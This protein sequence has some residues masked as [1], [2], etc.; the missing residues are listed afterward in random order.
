MSEEPGGAGIP[1]LF[2]VADTGAGHRMSAAAVARRLGDLYPG[3]FSVHVLDPFNDAAPPPVG[4]IVGLYSPVI[5]HA[6]WLW[7]ALFHATDSAAAVATLRSTVLRVVE[8]GLRRF[9]RSLRPAAVVS[10]H[11]LLNHVAARVLRR[12]EPPHV[13]LVTVITDLVDVH[14]AWVCRQADAVV[15]ASPSGVDRCRRAGVAAEACHD[16]GL[17]VDAAFGGTAS[18]DRR[19]AAREALGLDPERFTVLLT[20]GGEGSGGLYRRVRALAAAEMP[21]QLVAVCGRN[22][23]LR[24]RLLNLACAPGVR[25]RVEGFVANMPQWLRAADLAVGKAGPG[26]IAEAL[27]SGVPL[28]LTAYV[29]GQERGNVGYV[30]ASGAGRY[31]PG[32]REMVDAV[33]ELSQPDSVRLAEMRSAVA[34]ASRPSATDRVAALVASHALGEAA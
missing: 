17:P 18:A 20:G 33:R 6:P 9:V 8:P 10:F 13:P 2:L 26:A 12:L 30:V 15:T 24:A 7:G 5:R 16:L 27:V 4:R 11:P 14:A 23:A 22:Q 32:V 29:P 1:L 3:R 28:L 34:H 31:V 19:R 25:L 21:L